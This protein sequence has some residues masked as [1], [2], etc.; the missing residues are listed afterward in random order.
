LKEITYKDK[1]YYSL[2]IPCGF[3]VISLFAFLLFWL[4]L[5]CSRCS[6]CCGVVVVVGG[7]TSKKHPHTQTYVPLSHSS[8]KNKQQRLQ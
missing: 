5:L 4:L 3:F 6:C 2:V 1:S 8:C 7:G